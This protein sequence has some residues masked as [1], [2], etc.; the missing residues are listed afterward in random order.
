MTTEPLTRWQN[1]GWGSA[2][3][4]GK[5]AFGSGPALP[6]PDDRG[7]QAILAG[8]GGGPWFLGP[9]FST[10]DICFACR[11]HWRPEPDRGAAEIP[12][13]SRIAAA[14]AALPQRAAAM[15]RNFG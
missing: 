13:V 8:H 2:I 1:R 7:P 4:E 12:K 11:V 3:V 15:T 10:L 5:A 14:T 9:R 6:G